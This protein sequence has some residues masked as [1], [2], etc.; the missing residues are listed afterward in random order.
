MDKRYREVYENVLELVGHTPLVRLNRITKGISSTVLAKLEYYN[1]G[2]SIKDRIGYYMLEIAEKEGIIKPGATIVEPTS[3]NT[4]VG[5]AIASLIKGYKMIFVI[6]DKMSEEKINLLK[7]FGA[8]VIITATD[9]P[10]DHPSN[11]IKLAERIVKES[12]N[13]YMPNQFSNKGN[14]LAHYNTT[15]PEIWYQTG[16]KIDVLV[17][18]MGTGGTISG[19]AK[20]LKEKNPDI[21]I[22]GVDPEGSVYHHKFY[23]TEGPVH[24]YK[25]EGI[26]EDFL[27]DTLDLSLI[28][29][30]IVVSDKDA[31]HTAR[32]LAIKE[33]I[34][35]GGSAGAAVY[36]ALEV[37]KKLDKDKTVVVILPDTG[38]NYLTKI[39]S[40]DWM[41]NHGFL[42]S[43]EEKIPVKEILKYKKY[44]LDKVITVNPEDT[45]EKAIK[46]MERYNISQ[47]P[48]VKDDIQIGSVSEKYIA[49]QLCKLCNIRKEECEILCKS[50]ISQIMEPPLPSFDIN[51]SI[52]NPLSI[53]RDKN[54][55]LILS[56]RKIVNIITSI[57]IINY[58]MRRY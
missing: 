7:A 42:E 48:V 57:D 39:Y 25:V 4:G 15:G 19:T 2:G 9:V 49:E 43:E 31:F 45:I 14:P 52:I 8:K 41:R 55:I 21:R 37:A 46:L 24:S 26:G 1:P 51:D 33:G 38:R 34:F 23:Q 11:Y 29:E 56:D 12:E 47:L 10:P 53:L 44:Q 30:V 58:Y 18:G 50:K 16:G 40:D 28:D 3:G 35:A 36:G 54:A 6:P 13:A 32:E 20:Y 27:P 5:L 22:V 17:A